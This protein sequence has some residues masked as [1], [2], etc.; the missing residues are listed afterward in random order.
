ML[1]TIVSLYVTAELFVGIEKLLLSKINPMDASLQS[2]VHT[3]K[4]TETDI[5]I[6]DPPKL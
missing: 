3:P 2:F 4:L 6:S 5:T 1:F